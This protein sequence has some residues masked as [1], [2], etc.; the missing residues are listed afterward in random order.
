MFLIFPYVLFP[1]N[2]QLSLFQHQIMMLYYF[3]YSQTIFLRCS[4]MESDKEK[5]LEHQVEQL[6]LELQAERNKNKVRI[7][8]IY[9]D[10]FSLRMLTF[11]RLCRMK[12]N[13]YVNKILKLYVVIADNILILT[14]TTFV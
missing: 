7:R 8:Q 6:R 3:N 1:E 2:F 12:S 4:E 9:L 14:C 5:S 13:L 10:N 11:C